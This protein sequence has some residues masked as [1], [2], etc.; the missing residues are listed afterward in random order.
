MILSEVLYTVSIC[1]FSFAYNSSRFGDIFDQSSKKK[2]FSTHFFTLSNLK[3]GESI[4]IGLAASS[5]SKGPQIKTTEP[6]VSIKVT[7]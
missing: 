7:N 6:M 2:A 3:Y 1:H 5:T 4:V